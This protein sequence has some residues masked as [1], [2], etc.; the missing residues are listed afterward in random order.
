MSKSRK[1]KKSQRT[2]GSTGNKSGVAFFL[3]DMGNYD[4]LC[5][6]YTTLD[7]NPEIYTACKTIAR[8]ISGMTIRL[9]SNTENGDVRIENELS[10]KIDINPN[11]FMT[12]R[13]FIE[14][15]VMNMLLYGEGNSVVRAHT[16]AGLLTDLE[17]IQ[18]NRV[19]FLTDGY[20]YMVTI[21]GVKYTPDEIIHFVDNP[22]PY[23][24]WKGRGIQVIVKDIANNLKQAQKT[25]N[26]FMTSQWRPSVIVKVD[27]LTDEFSSPEGRKKLLN[28]YVKSS[29]I[30]EPWLIPADQFSVEQIRPLS[31]SDL[32]ISDSVEIDKK[33]VASIVGVP[34]FVL[35]VGEYNKNAWNSFIQNTVKPIAQGLE[36]ELTR[37]LI[38]NPKWYLKFNIL[39]LMDWDIKTI[40]DVFGGLSDRGIVDGNEVRDRIGMDPREGLDELRVLEN[41]IPLDM[42]A[43]QKKLIQTGDT[44]GE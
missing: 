3:S 2:A 40:A 19:A 24:P 11:Q 36:Q 26:A 33:T 27:A 41:Y 23:Y 44:G 39:S 37:K 4:L 12:R 42:A 25:K 34:P 22:D 13:T 9:M 1:K 15:V 16:N 10:R 17:P 29:E 8:L 43:L 7:K 18:P 38:L 14:Y 35:G 30:G 28:E 6:G 21:D 32:A 20:G 31:L 5:P